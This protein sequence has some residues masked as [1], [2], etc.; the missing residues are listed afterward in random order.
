MI[1]GSRRKFLKGA[2]GTAAAAAMSAALPAWATA[3]E[4]HS[5]KVW[6]TYADKRYATAEPLAWQPVTE[7]GA[8]AIVIDPA[9]ENQEVLGFGGALTDA[10]CWVLSQMKADERSSAMHDLFAPREMGMNVCRTCIGASDYSRTAYTFDESSEPDPELKKFSIDHDKEY[11]LPILREARKVNPELFLF[12]SPWSPPGWMKAGGSMM[13]GSMRKASYDPYAKYF[14]KFLQGYEA[15]GVRI[16]AVTVQ[17]EV[18]ADQDGRMPACLW[19]QE[20][21]IEFVKDH[22]GP[23][24]RDAGLKTKIWVLDHNYNLWGR[25]MAELADPKAYEFIDGIAW[26]P[27]V[28]D[29]TAMTRVHEAY[30]KRSAYWTEGGPDVTA[31]DYKTDWAKWGE[32]FNGALN[33]WARSITAWNIALDEHGKPNIGP[34]PCG[35]VITVESGS[36]AITKSGQYWAFAHFSRHVRRGA[37]V[38][39][40]NGP[41]VPDTGGLIENRQSKALTHAG[42][43]NPDG[44]HAVILANRGES[45]RAQLVLGS[46]G[47]DVQMPAD[48][49]VTLA[50]S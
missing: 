28:G 50:W 35:G 21:E 39:A 22:L 20:Y 8:E 41:D 4:S 49:L 32:I 44:S 19:G 1:A 5:V 45:R 12:S 33:N 14:L 13:G 42:F 11:I 29:A 38:I 43:R 46:M 48:S 7:I 18:D 47:L 37:R 30:P 16:D 15:D 25:A 27:Y 34:F 6:Q 26:H 24:L 40:T 10:T 9:T 31:P 36:H 3:D 23:T 17:N 2:A